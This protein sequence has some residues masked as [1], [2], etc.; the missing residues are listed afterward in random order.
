[1]S[2][3]LELHRKSLKSLYNVYAEVSQNAKDAFRD[4]DLMSIGEWLHF[5][6]H[7]G[8]KESGQLTVAAAK[9][10]FLWSRIR[11]VRLKGS[12]AAEGPR[13]AK[14][15]KPA[16]EW[17][18]LRSTDFDHQSWDHRNHI[19]ACACTYVRSPSLGTGHVW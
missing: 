16:A 11:G 8:L 6:D 5:V 15:K 9:N 18:E 10:I 19:Y 3:V 17:L 1:M 2:N 4:D 7:I 13:S 12:E 14:G